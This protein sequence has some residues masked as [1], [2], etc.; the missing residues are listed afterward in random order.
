VKTIGLRLFEVFSGR[1]PGF[2]DLCCYWF[3]KARAQIA[4]GKTHRAGLLA[5]QSIRGG[6]SRQVL[7]RIKD[8][9][10]IF[11]A[12]SDRNWELAGATVHVSMVGFDRGVETART[13]DGASVAS[14]NS[15]LTSLSD[16]TTARRL[17][18]NAE[19]WAYGSQQKG[20]FDIEDELARQFLL[21]PNP[22]GK[23]NSDV[24]R[25]S[26]NSVQLLRR[27][28]LTWVID[29]GL[30]RDIAKAAAY[31]GP[32]KYCETHLQPLRVRHREAVQRNHW[33][34]H[35]R[36]SPVYRAFASAGPQI[37][38]TP[39]VSKHRIF[40]WV[41]SA[42]I[43]DHA[44]IVFDASHDVLLGLLHSRIH[45][46]W[47]R[48]QATQVRDRDSGLRYTPKSC[49]ETFPFPFPLAPTPPPPGHTQAEVD[50]AHHYFMAKE[51]A[52]PYGDEAAHRAAIA[53]A[54]SELNALRE[55]WLNP[56]EW[57]HAEHLEFPAS[58]GGPWDRFINRAT[59]RHGVGTARYPRLV[60]NDAAAAQ[61]LK[62]RT[63]TA[64]YNER[65]AWLDHAHRQL[66]AA[67]AAA[68]GWPA[69][70]AD[71]QIL[72][73]LLALNLARA[74]SERAAANS[75]PATSTPFQRPKADDELI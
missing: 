38:V 74:A 3:E 8:G 40:T 33:W 23:P 75:S 62:T 45:E 36:P 29:F 65:P 53:A 16:T 49:F 22:S 60:P 35:A 55:R 64:L 7:E 51:D 58:I 10:D 50:A 68:Y 6:A 28:G 14:I 1:V 32:F 17:S 47:S 9:G 4:E 46:V 66:D 41:D 30:E 59:V 71:A 44:L 11:F 37:L 67:V 13:L 61:A 27:T 70:L 63:L 24:V 52:A 12:V 69:D 26:Y 20:P 15:D 39:G 57:T 5:T 2:A 34:L 73:R 21:A 56:P 31:A 43:P 54:A 48:R 18:D 42:G 72:A 19:L 25:P